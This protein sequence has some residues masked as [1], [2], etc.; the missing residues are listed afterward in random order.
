MEL[1][2][3]A[4]RTLEARVALGALHRSDS[5]VAKRHDIFLRHLR[6]FAA[7]KPREPE[8]QANE[9]KPQR[10]QERDAL[11]CAGLRL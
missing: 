6:S 10:A 2:L 5:T 8:L 11:P 3:L 7:K 1:P 9:M 4:A